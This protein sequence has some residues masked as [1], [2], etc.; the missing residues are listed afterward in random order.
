MSATAGEGHRS[1]Q[2]EV[3]NKVE[4]CLQLHSVASPTSAMSEAFDALEEQRSDYRDNIAYVEDA[5]GVAVAIGKQVVAL[6]VFDKP[7]TCQKVWDRLLSGC[8]LDAL[9]AES[10]DGQAEV[11]EVERLLSSAAAAEWKRVQP[12]GEGVEYR[13]EFDED[14]M[15][16]L[17]FADT[18]VHA[19]V[20]AQC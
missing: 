7:S 19:S 15:S 4:E 5:T 10:K 1:N 11:A 17:S 16:V 12:V 2:G 20:V 9:D 3:W 8:I 6:D 18:L 14:Q 13:S